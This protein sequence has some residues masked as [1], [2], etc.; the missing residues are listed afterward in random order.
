M[1]VLSLLHEEGVGGGI[2]VNRFDDDDDDNNHQGSDSDDE[3]SESDKMQQ[4]NQVLDLRKK[5]YI[6]FKSH[7]LKLT[8]LE[9]MCDS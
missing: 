4:K 9:G 8:S 2:S 3:K 5:N 1:D 7:N 6:L